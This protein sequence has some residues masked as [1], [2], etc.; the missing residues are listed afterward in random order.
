MFAQHSNIPSQ[1]FFPSAGVGFQAAHDSDFLPQFL[2][3]G[4]HKLNYQNLWYH[5]C[6]RLNLQNILG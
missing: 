3:R 2:L 5:K 6:V 4:F 1:T